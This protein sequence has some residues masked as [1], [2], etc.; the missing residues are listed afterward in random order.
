MSFHDKKMHEIFGSLFFPHVPYQEIPEL[1]DANQC[2]GCEIET[3]DFEM[4]LIADIPQANLYKNGWNIV[5]EHSVR[6]GYELIF[7]EPLKGP[8]IINAYSYLNY[9]Y[10]SI[11]KTIGRYP[12]YSNRTSVHI[13][14]DVRPYTVKQLEKLFY[15]YVLF[16][17]VL[18]SYVGHG[19]IKSNYC[20]PLIGSNFLQTL[21]SLFD[22]DNC[23]TAIKFRGVVNSH[24]DKYM[25]LNFRPLL[26]FGSVEFRHHYGTHD[27]H[28][29]MKWTNIILSLSKFAKQED[30]SLEKLIEMDNENIMET[31]FGDVLLFTQEYNF[32]IQTGKSVVKFLIST[33]ELKD[34][35]KKV[36]SSGKRKGA[37]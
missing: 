6:N 4:D 5:E 34:I 20:K 35:S 33:D 3:E 10:N 24:S 2:I 14:L 21:P 32:L 17:R 19:R 28:D 22:I 7:K 36:V 37:L 8:E 15:T 16:E 30:I 23:N 27:Y 11:D 25:A 9:V 1:V 13:H 31:V 26:K 29:L 18:F 12:S